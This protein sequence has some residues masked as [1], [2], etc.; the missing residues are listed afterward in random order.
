MDKL[1]SVIIPVYNVERYVTK[2]VK[3]VCAQTYSNLEIIIVNDGSTDNSA[4]ICEQLSLQD[5]RIKIV[6]KKNGGLSDARN[7]GLLISSGD[8]VTFVDSDDFVSKN[9]ISYLYN[10]IQHNRADVAICDPAHFSEKSPAKFTDASIEKNY[11]PRDAIIEMLYQRSFLV[12]AW[13][14]L[15]SKKLFDEIKFPV[16]MLYEDSAVMYQLFDRCEKI[17]YGNAKYYGYF[18]REGSITTN[19]FSKKDLDILTICNQIETYFSGRKEVY[20]N[21]INSYYVAA[22]LRI[23]LNAPDHEFRQAKLN[24]EEIINNRGRKVLQ[25][26]NVR[27]K[28]K[29]ALLLFYDFRILMPLIYRHIDRWR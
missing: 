27:K 12:S 7:A 5:Q 22:A 15:Y 18:H 11:S 23:Y 24:A 25:D 1:I 3:S 4:S 14:K 13:G 6:N 10:L 16:G 28:E 2:C 29:L 19:K 20:E 17:T 26:K 9:I 8:Y 21:A